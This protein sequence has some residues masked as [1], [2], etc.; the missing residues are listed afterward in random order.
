MKATL[1]NLAGLPIGKSLYKAVQPLVHMARRFKYPN[2]PL[3][4]KLTEVT[5]EGRTL[6]IESRRWSLSD[7][8]AIEQCFSERQ[9]DFPVGAHGILV[10]RTY[11]KIVDSGKKP[12]IVDGGANIGASVLWFSARY[13]KA[14]IV[15]IEPSLGNFA[16]LKR[17]C[18]HLDVTLIQAGLAAKDG[19]AY[20]TEDAGEM[21]CRTVST[22]NDKPIDMVSLQTILGNDALSDYVPFLLKL[23]IEG[24]ET[25]LFDGDCSSFNSF[26]LIIMEPHDWLFPGKH[27][28][29]GFFKFHGASG[30]EFSMKSENIAS[31]AMDESLLEMKTGLTN[32]SF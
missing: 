9:Y 14:H 23:D 31:I 25:D 17:N 24:G 22:E 5:Y 8:L 3:D 7:A 26:P 11:Q 30:R 29:S 18:E 16:L 10:K 4:H 32:G 12:I 1:S 15:A 27:S 2:I 20:L 19:R 28:S 21:G 6:N 13:P